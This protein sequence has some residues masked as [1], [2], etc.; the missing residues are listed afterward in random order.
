MFIR[1]LFKDYSQ[2]LQVLYPPQEAE[3][4]SF[5]LFEHFMGLK[6]MDIL[7]DKQVTADPAMEEAMTRLEQGMPIQYVTGSAPFYGRDFDVT[8]AVLIPRNETEE[9]VHLIIA[10]N[11]EQDLRILD[12]GTGSGCIPIT[13][14]LE[15]NRPVLTALDISE[16]ALD[17]ARR[18][19][20]KYGVAIDFL[21]SDVLRDELPVYDLDL[22]I[23]NPPY[24]RESEKKDMHINVLDHES[25]LALFVPEE[26]PLI[27]YRIIAHKGLAAL[28]PGGRLYFEINEALG[29]ALLDM[30]SQM[31]YQHL[32]IRKDLNGRDRMVTATRS[33]EEKLI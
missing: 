21:Q 27:F 4:L 3:S 19:A 14:A 20:D 31:G 18:N 5:W 23:S 24:V 13:L 7:Q 17:V 25:H 22:L 9:L 32:M 2:R 10:E 15:M 1:Q 12:I 26:D 33:K 30:L 6:R 11:P 16:T 29:A 28:K 8:S